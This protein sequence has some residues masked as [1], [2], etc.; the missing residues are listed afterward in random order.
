MSALEASVR[1]QQSAF[2]ILT[3]KFEQQTATVESLTVS[4]N[5]VLEKLTL[6]SGTSDTAGQA[7]VE[8]LE[9]VER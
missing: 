6:V 7:T 9:Q 2:D 3:K 8:G 5:D 4:M 1:N